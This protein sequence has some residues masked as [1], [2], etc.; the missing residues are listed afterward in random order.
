MLPNKIFFFIII[1]IIFTIK[2]DSKSNSNDE[3][4][5]EGHKQFKEQLKQYLIETKLLN[6][7]K[8][9]ER[10]EMKKIFIDVMTEK[11]PQYIPEFLKAI[12]DKLSKY[13]IDKY[14]KKKKIIKGKDIY[15]LINMEEISMKFQQITGNPDFDFT[16]LD[17]E[18]EYEY[19]E[20]DN[21]NKKT[22]DL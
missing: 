4:N 20:E 11:D 15:D 1:T 22:S 2:C 13:F 6:S 14:Y 3:S 9:I 18:E 10:E 5:D 19:E 12:L 21:T 17:D 7:E 8:P 16:E